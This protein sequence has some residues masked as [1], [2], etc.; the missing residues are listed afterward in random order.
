MR[1]GA[2]SNCANQSL[3]RSARHRSYAGRGDLERQTRAFHPDS[4]RWVEQN[5]QRSRLMPAMAAGISKTLWSMDD[6]CQMIDKI[7]RKPEPCGPHRKPEL[8]I[9]RGIRRRCCN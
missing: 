1:R 3:Q 8:R 2:P 7:A 5:G 4:G 9:D 6:L